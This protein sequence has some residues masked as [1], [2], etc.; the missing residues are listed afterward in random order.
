MLYL[1][2]ILQSLIQVSTLNKKGFLKLYKKKK[3]AEKAHIKAN[4]LNYE[5][6]FLNN[7]FFDDLGSHRQF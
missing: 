5:L 3:K 1:H 7:Q 6:Y 4:K 2:V